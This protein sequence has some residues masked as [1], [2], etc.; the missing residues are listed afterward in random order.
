MRQVH[1]DQIAEKVAELCE[2]AT[3]FL[4][5]D[6]VAALERARETEQSPLGKQVLVEILENVEL[7]KREMIPL[8]QDTGT[9]VVFVELG[10]DVHIVG[11]SLAEAINRGVS[12]GYTEGYLRASMVEHP[13]SSRTNTKDNTPA[14]I[15][16]DLVPGD[17]FK[18][19]VLP[20]G[21]GCENMTRF[22]IMLP[23]EGKEGITNF[24]LR[25][26]EESGGN[27][28]PP[29]VVGVGV[30]G[31]SEYAMYLAK[32]AVTRKVGQR[33]ADP[34]TAQFEEELLEKVNALG[35]GP[36]AVGGLNTALTVN[37]ETYPTHI[38]ALP[39]AV[40]LQCH[41]ARL[42]EAEL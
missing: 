14:V 41:S 7:A 35:V 26:V 12:K 5:E 39:V 23:S 15:H 30:G 38:T 11:G 19:K 40:N 10:Q 24:V 25:A 16:I 31:T 27:A 32:K 6:V 13:F 18:I 34:E 8:C 9:T 21:G 17:A 20:K 4:P 42:K 36:Q 2:M 22:T 1:V 33:S 28:C 37:I 3:H 29:L